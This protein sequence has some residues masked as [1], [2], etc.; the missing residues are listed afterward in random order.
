[1][2]NHRASPEAHESMT[3]SR[4]QELVRDALAGRSLTIPIGWTKAR[5]DGVEGERDQ[6][7]AMLTY[8]LRLV[9]TETD[10]V[11]RNLA[12]LLAVATAARIRDLEGLGLMEDLARHTLKLADTIDDLLEQRGTAAAP[13]A[14]TLRIDVANARG[15]IRK[16][17]KRNAA[18]DITE[19]LEEPVA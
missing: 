3:A 5:R 1:M 19:V 10:P 4:A 8:A 12:G 16:V 14:P 6:A 11:A 15:T 9:D 7:T 18:G 17:V 13:T 2:N